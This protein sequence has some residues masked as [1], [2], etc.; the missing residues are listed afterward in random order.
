MTHN[1][2]GVN[3]RKSHLKDDTPILIFKIDHY[4]SASVF[5]VALADYYYNMSEGVPEKLTKTEAIVILKRQLKFYGMQ[6]EFPDGSFEGSDEHIGNEREKVYRQ[7]KNWVINHYP[8][9]ITKT[10]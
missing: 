1:I 4:V 7:A 2:Y 6:G 10:L 9:L 3:M 5:T 8:Y